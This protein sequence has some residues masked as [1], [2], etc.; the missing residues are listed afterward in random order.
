M[1]SLLPWLLLLPPPV[2][3]APPPH[4]KVST[5]A[6]E[7]PSAPSA[8]STRLRPK[9]DTCADVVLQSVAEAGRGVQCSAE[10]LAELQVVALLSGVV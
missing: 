6:S 9:S 8:S 3:A 10:Q 4:E 2:L 7:L 5:T 1:P